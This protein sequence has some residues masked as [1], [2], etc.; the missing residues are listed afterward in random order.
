[1]V[2]PSGSGKSTLLRALAGLVRIEGDL[3]V[4]GRVWQSPGSFTPP[5]RREVGYVF[6]HAALLSHLTVRGNLEYARRRS[7]AN[8]DALDDV[9]GRL[10]LDQLLERAPER[11]SGG[12]RQRVAVAR[13]LLTRP[14]LLLLDEPLAGLDNAT[15]AV[16]LPDLQAAIA[17]LEAPVLYVSHDRG[18][19]AR[20]AGRTLPLRNGRIVTDAW[21]ATDEEELAGR[22]DAQ[23][24][25]LAAAALRAGLG[26]GGT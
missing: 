23:V 9:V 16:L 26:E 18:E 3:T 2:G 8:A 13:A 14:K 24:R 25:R 11:L 5:H 15:K 4:A 10:R 6:Q 17:A 19:V 1:M 22:T 12:E 21:L 20:M 7:Q